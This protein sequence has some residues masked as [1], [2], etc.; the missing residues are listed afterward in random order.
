MIGTPSS[1]RIDGARIGIV[2][3][4]KFIPEEIGAYTAGFPLLGAQV[5]LISRIHYD[6]H[7]PARATLY[8]DV[9]PLDNQ[10]WETPHAIQVEKDISDA[11]VSDYAA[12]IMAANYTSVRLRYVSLPSTPAKFDPWAHVRAAPTARFFA[13]AMVNKDIVKGALCHGLWILTPYPSLLSGRTVICHSVVMADIL[14]CGAKVVLTQD[15]VVTDDDLVTAFSK[16][17]VG[18]FIVAVA[19][20]IADRRGR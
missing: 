9:D 16:H 6:D 4:N 11:R 13:E 19:E 10:P 7:R 18:P 8:S 5:E 2:L 3:E 12:V 15:K 1:P 14:N 20:C 17:E